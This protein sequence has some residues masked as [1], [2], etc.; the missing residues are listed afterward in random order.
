M[1]RCV[2]ACV[3]ACAPAGESLLNDGTALVLYTIFS[4][5][6]LLEERTIPEQ[7]GFF[8]RLALGGFGT[9]IVVGVLTVLVFQLMHSSLL[10]TTWTVAAAYL[11]F[12]MCENENVHFSGVIAVVFLGVTVSLYGQTRLTSPEFMENFWTMWNFIANTLIF[13]I[14]GVI[15]VESVFFE[16]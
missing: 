3:R 8:F 9:G 15:V 6:L 11:T 14:T 2:R 13:S 16:S 1:Q 7:F 5:A 4:Q 12:F 10:E